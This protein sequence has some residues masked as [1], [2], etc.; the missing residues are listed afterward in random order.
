MKFLANNNTENHRSIIIN[1]LKLHNEAY[2]AVA[3]LKLSGLNKIIKPIEEFLKAGGKITIIAGQ[4]F[5]FTEPMALHLLRK[6][7]QSNQSSK[8]YLAKA[9]SANTV[10]HLKLY[11]FKSQNNC[12]IISGSANI[13]EGGLVN[14]KETSLI[15]TCN[16]TDTIWKEAKIY[17]DSQ[18]APNNADEASLL[19]IKQ[20]ETFFEQQKQHNKKSKPIPTKT[21]SQLTFDYGNLLRHFQKFNNAKRQ[22]NIKDKLNNYKEAKRVLDEIADNSRLTQKQF[23]PLLD[24]LVGS[25]EEDNLWHSGSLF[26]LRRRVYPYYKEFRDLIRYIRENKSLPQKVVFENAKEKVEIIE[27]AAVNYITEIMMTYNHMDFANINK[28]PITVLRTEGGVNIKAS[29]SSYTGLDYEEYCDLVKEISAKLGLQN[30]LEADSFFN[31]IYWKI[32]K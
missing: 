18:L 17:F 1:N 22:D 7:F 30:M 19:I 9:N 27:G 23:E 5:A 21:K 11:L 16:E 26:R 15:A 6:L 24:T 4:N 3:F 2:F 10:F 28:N 32:K 13:T 25:K 31:D 20:Y 12:C 14:N 8:L 29:T